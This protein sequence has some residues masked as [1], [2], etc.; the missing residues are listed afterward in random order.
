MFFLSVP[1][2]SR[3]LIF[4]YYHCGRWNNCS[5]KSQFRYVV[6]VS[7]LIII[8]R[9]LTAYFPSNWI[10][11]YSQLV[12]ADAR[13]PS[14]RPCSAKQNE[15]RLLIW[16]EGQADGKYKWNGSR[17]AV[18]R[19]GF[20]KTRGYE[21]KVPNWTRTCG[22]CSANPPVRAEIFAQWLRRTMETRN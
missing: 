11:L 14:P 21:T 13:R 1:S 20:D 2:F 12:S 5:L 8:L 6:I 7:L 19:S 18:V 9:S 10:A 16:G 17:R 3:T 4:L 15:I 22:I